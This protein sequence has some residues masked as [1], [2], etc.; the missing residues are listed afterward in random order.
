MLSLT[1][2]LSRWVEYTWNRS[3]TASDFA[4]DYLAGYALRNGI[5]IYGLPLRHL[6][7]QLLQLQMLDNYHPPFNAIL[8]LPFSFLPYRPAFFLWN[9]FSLL[10]YVGIILGLLKSLGLLTFRSVRAIPR[11]VDLAVIV[12]PPDA[13]LSTAEQCGE[14]GV[15]GLV[16][17]TAGFRE[18]GGVGIE[19][20]RRLRAI[21]QRFG[22]R[23]VGP[24]CMGVINTEPEFAC[25][26]SF[27]AT[28][29]APGSVAMVSQSG[30]LG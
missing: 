10:I 29:P 21:A 16:V 15:K 11:A 9:F 19:R 23:V 3:T 12:V 18:I 5:E 22:M 25:N 20:E 17:I 4:Q 8:F 28:L 24:N 27:S 30:A 14:K 6:G 1:L 13:V 2:G 7:Q 26:A